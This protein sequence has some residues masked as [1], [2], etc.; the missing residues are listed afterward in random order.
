MSGTA[1]QNNIMF[2][3]SSIHI[4]QNKQPNTLKIYRDSD[5]DSGSTITRQFCGDCGSNLFAGN[6][7]KMPDAILVCGGT[8]NDEENLLGEEALTPKLE[9]Y[10]KD[11]R[12]WVEGGNKEGVTCKEMM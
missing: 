8:L 4:T 10:C 12:A 6:D 7:E 2:S 9:F 3:K 11:R 1:F 5:T